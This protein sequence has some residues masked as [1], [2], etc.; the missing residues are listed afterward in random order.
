MISEGQIAELKSF[1]QYMDA[2]KPRPREVSEA[3][4]KTYL[5][6]LRYDHFADLQRSKAQ[7]VEAVDDYLRKVESEKFDNPRYNGAENDV[8]RR[9]LN[10]DFSANLKFAS[11]SFARFRRIGEPPSPHYIFRLGLLLRKEKNVDLSQRLKT[12]WGRHCF[13]PPNWPRFRTP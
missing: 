9:S 2:L 11:M 5:D 3:K 13:V 7:R 1:I 8:I 4:H 12:A 10:N 6:N